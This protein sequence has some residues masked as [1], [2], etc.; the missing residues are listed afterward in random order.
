MTLPLQENL[1]GLEMAP[2]CCVEDLELS[3]IVNTIITDA[4]DQDALSNQTVIPNF[5][6]KYK[7]WIGNTTSN[8]VLGLENF[9][10]LD[11]TQGT[12]E[13]F[14]KFYI[15]YREKRFRFF[16]GEY[17]YHKISLENSNYAIIEN[18]E[19]L[20]END[21]VIVSLPFADTGNVHHFFDSKFL[22]ICHSK[23]IPV[24]LDCA[25]FGICSN[26]KFDFTHPAIREVCFSLSKTFP[27]NLL[28]IGMR[29]SKYTDLDG[30]GAY[31]NS[32][33]QNRLSA[34]VGLKIL[35]LRTADSTYNDYRSS[36]L[37]FCNKFNLIPSNTV[38]FGL[39]Q[40]KKYQQYNRG[41]DNN[42]RICFSKFYRS[43]KYYNCKIDY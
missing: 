17:L 22:D 7:Q 35:E 42:N 6:S 31:T 26:I 8:V 1:L 36:Q 24:L 3:K 12:S 27:V 39:D 14:D 15:R 40:A 23:N 21:A 5:L 33:Y 30:I 41:S 25:Y 28:R 32:Q 20:L 10:R 2:A 9:N 29:F 37:E 11:F 34:Y 16:K 4:V 13:A 19:D 18:P 43:T 38:I